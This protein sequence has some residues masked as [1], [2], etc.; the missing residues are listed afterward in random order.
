MPARVMRAIRRTAILLCISLFLQLLRYIPYLGS[1]IPALWL[2]KLSYHL[3]Q[4]NANFA[5]RVLL[6]AGLVVV[7]VVPWVREM[8]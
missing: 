1:F 8:E 4:F 7:A 3:I 5:V 2:M 6:S